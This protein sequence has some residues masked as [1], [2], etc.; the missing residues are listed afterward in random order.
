MTIKI[1]LYTISFLISVFVVSGLNIN[2]IF[3]KNKVWEARFFI[4]TLIIVIS[5]ILQSFLYDIV[6]MSTL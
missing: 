3:Q 5:Y 6:T 1:C 2:H 4:V